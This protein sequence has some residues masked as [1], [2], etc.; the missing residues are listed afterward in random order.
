MP[1]TGLYAHNF[2]TPSASFGLQSGFFAFV[3]IITGLTR[4]T[5]LY[6]KILSFAGMRV[7]IPSLKSFYSGLKSLSAH[8]SLIE[9]KRKKY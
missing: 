9:T 7:Q 3:S 5:I 8:D 6:W 4:N 2:R 1:F